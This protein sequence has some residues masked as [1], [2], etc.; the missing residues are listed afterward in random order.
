MTFYR[1]IL[2]AGGVLDLDF[3]TGEQAAAHADY[4]RA[5]FFKL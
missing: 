2:P 1:F 4:L 5:R 3:R